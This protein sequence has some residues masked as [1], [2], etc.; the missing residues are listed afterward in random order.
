[1]ME[2][3][4]EISNWWLPIEPVEGEELEDI[5]SQFISVYKNSIPEEE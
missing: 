4:G 1:M 3:L 2:D 5:K